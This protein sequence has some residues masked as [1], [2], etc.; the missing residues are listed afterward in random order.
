[1]LVS[2]NELRKY[3]DLNGLDAE[4][5][6]TRLTSAGVEVESI[7]K[8]AF[9]TKLVVGEVIK[10]ENMENS[11]HLHVTKVNCGPKYGTLDIVCGAPN[12]RTGLKVIVALD[13]CE[14]KGGT[15]KKGMIRGHESNGMLCS[16]VELGVDTKFLSEAQQKGI[17]ELPSD[18]EVGNEEV[19]AYFGLDEIGRAHV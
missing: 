4:E 8:A 6:A 11:D 10:C 3:V 13:G 17:E 12:C 7:N 15:I 16:L 1:M 14:L 19:L 5:I 18:A 2:L 9:A